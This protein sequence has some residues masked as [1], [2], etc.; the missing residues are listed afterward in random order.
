ML[1]A[2]ALLVPLALHLLFERQARRLDALADH[3]ATTTASVTRVS[4]DFA[5]YAYDVDGLSHTW[6]VGASDVP[7]LGERFV[8]RYLPE[9]PSFSRPGADPSVAASEAASNRSF[10]W[11]LLLGIFWFFGTFALQGAFELAVLRRM[12]AEAY[13]RA[14]ALPARMRRRLVLV[15][16]TLL[17]ILAVIVG[18]HALDGAKHGEPPAVALIGGALSLAVLGGAL[19]YALR[20]GPGQASTRAARMMRWGVPIAFG[21]AA[22]RVLAMLV[23]L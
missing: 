1:A 23:S 21:V 18:W 14:D 6:G 22:L 3:G 16:I 11:K 7:A 10:A 5:D 19:A 9:E 20:E 2:I 12:G 4:G 8:V 15:A 17:P 13:A